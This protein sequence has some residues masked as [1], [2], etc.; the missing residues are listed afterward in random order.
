MGSKE[1]NFLLADA[2]R[3]VINT[4]RWAPPRVSA[5]IKKEKVPTVTYAK[6]EAPQ[7]IA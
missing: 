1:L 4:N 7:E 6:S 2:P 3:L 5:Q